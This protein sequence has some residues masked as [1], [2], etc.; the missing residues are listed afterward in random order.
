M[1]SKVSNYVEFWAPVA[2]GAG[3]AFTIVFSKYANFSWSTWLGLIISIV[4]IIAGVIYAPQK[5]GLVPW[6]RALTAFGFIYLLFYLPATDWMQV[7]AGAI[8][9]VLWFLLT[10]SRR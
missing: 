8:A 6:S 7:L 10:P 2:I 4:M 1:K 9:I 5:S 3:V